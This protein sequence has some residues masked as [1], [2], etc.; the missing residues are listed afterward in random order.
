MAQI[1]SGFMTCALCLLAVGLYGTLS[2]CVLQR[3]REIGIRIAVG[4]ERRSILGLV[5]RQGF[6]WIAIGIVGGILAS[7]ALG[8]VVQSQIWGLSA[9][10]PIVLSL[11]ALFV[12]L[13]ATVAVCLP[14]LRAARVDPIVALRAN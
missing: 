5:F 9:I 6:A 12:A 13:V 10:N 7:L 4:A 8:T 3:T 2:Y 11:S 1:V 14:A